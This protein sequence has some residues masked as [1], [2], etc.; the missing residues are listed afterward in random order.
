MQESA[1]TAKG[2]T[3]LPRAV[4]NALGVT[5]GDRVRYIVEGN[6][7]RLIKVR[8]VMEL[9]GIL[10]DATRAPASLED[11]DAGAAAGAAFDAGLE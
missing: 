10:H 9:K 3:T 4:R 8:S 1:I 11:M 2:Q 6:E 7:V 5:A